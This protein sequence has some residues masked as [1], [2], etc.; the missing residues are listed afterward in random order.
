MFTC[1]LD[2]TPPM[3]F[4]ILSMIQVAAGANAKKSSSQKNSF[5]P[6]WSFVGKERISSPRSTMTA[7]VVWTL[8]HLVLLVYLPASIKLIICWRASVPIQ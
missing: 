2:H 4:A 7:L 5:S 6:S 8:A 1:A 3:S